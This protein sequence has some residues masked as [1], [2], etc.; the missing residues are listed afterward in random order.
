MYLKSYKEVSQHQRA[1]K[2]GKVHSYKRERTLLLFK[3]DSC[4]K[5]F[6]RYRSKMSPKR[7]SNSYFHICENC[8]AK[9]FAQKKGVEKRKIW[10][11]PAGIDL[12]VGRY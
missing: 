6:T 3:C 4:D 9:R 1:S 2:T 7:I 10:D 5:E 11:M 8:D 12:P